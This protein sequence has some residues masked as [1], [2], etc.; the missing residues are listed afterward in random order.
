ME[1]EMLDMRDS[2]PETLD[3]VGKWEDDLDE[4]DRPTHEKPSC[5]MLAWRCTMWACTKV[6]KV[7]PRFH[8]D[9]KRTW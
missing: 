8:W 2:L 6:A 4:T 1:M 7:V 3:E 5:M 9:G